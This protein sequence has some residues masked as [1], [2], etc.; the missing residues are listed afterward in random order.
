MKVFELIPC[1]DKA[2]IISCCWHLKKNL[3]N[4]GSLD[5]FKALLVARGF[6]QREVLDFDQTFVPS[7]R[8]VS[9]KGFLSVVSHKDWEV[10]QLDVV[11]AF[12]YGLLDEVMYMNQPEGFEDA[13]HPDHVWRL[14]TSLYGLK[15]SARQWHLRFTGHLQHLGFTCSTADPSVYIYCKDGVPL[16]AVLVHVNDTILAAK[17][18]SFSNSRTSN[19]NPSSKCPARVPSASSCPLILLATV[20]L[21]PSPLARPLTWPHFST[22]LVSRTHAWVPPLATTI[23]NTL[24][25]MVIP[26]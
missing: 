7:S 4:D 18:P 8:Q 5:K 17:T 12:L 23:S 21:K 16:A 19:C 1:P 15:Q 11:A 25:G 2:K 6:T 3:K 26:C 22:T 14:N 9:L 13:S 24:S 20:R 10:I